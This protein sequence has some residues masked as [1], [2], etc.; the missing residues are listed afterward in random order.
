MNND[1]RKPRRSQ[2]KTE[3]EKDQNDRWLLT[4]AD[5]ITL[6]L[7]LFIV[8]YSISTVDMGKL[9]SVASVIRGGFGLDDG[10]ESLVLDGQSGVIKDKDLVPKSQIYRLWEKLTATIKR[11]FVT[12]KVLIE[13]QN[14]EELTLTIPAGSLGDGKIHLPEETSQLFKNL[15]DMDKE[16]PLDI[17]IRVQIPYLTDLDKNSFQSNWDFTAHR[18]SLIAKHLSKKFNIPEESISVQGISQ[19]KSFSGKE[20]ETLEGLANQE[21]VEILI[22]KR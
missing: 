7:G 11:V 15:S 10:G 3:P 17:I 21:R 4:Y 22:R 19:F 12:D 18:A 14:K 1:L 16:V 2:K 6:L 9:K 20:P 13:L 5:M 8:M